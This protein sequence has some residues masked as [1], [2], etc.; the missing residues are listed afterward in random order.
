MKVRDPHDTDSTFQ[1][2]T[3]ES[4]AP[5]NYTACDDEGD[6]LAYEDTMGLDCARRSL[7]DLHFPFRI[8]HSS[9]D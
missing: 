3:T 2:P 6:V 1:E 4:G 7:C 5:F 9:V 8:Y